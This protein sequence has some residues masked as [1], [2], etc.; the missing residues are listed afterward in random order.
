VAKVAQEKLALPDGLKP[1]KLRPACD[2]KTLG[3]VTTDSFPAEHDL[4][5]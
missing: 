2:P 3:F 4:V 1:Q 5:G